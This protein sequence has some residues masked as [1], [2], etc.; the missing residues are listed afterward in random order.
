MDTDRAVLLFLPLTSHL[1]HDSTAILAGFGC[2]PRHCATMGLLKHDCDICVWICMAGASM[3]LG[4]TQNFASAHTLLGC[5]PKGLHTL[6]HS[7]LE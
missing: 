7:A 5:E 1:L 6:A 3:E 2:D 4:G